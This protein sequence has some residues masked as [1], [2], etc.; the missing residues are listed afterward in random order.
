MA[1]SAASP[2]VDL[3]AAADAVRENEAIVASSRN[4]RQQD[5]LAHTA[6]RVDLRTDAVHDRFCDI[7]PR[8]AERTQET[9]GK[10]L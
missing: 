6:S 1:G 10:R 7:P 8:F 2:L 9:I 3:L 4:A 5:P